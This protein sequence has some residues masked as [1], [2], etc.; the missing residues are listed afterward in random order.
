MISTSSCNLRLQTYFFIFYFFAH[1]DEPAPSHP[2]TP[3]K[4]ASGP[5]IKL[6]TARIHLKNPKNQF[7]TCQRLSSSSHS[8]SLAPPLGSLSVVKEPLSTQWAEWQNVRMALDSSLHRNLVLTIS[9][10]CHPSHSRTISYCVSF[11]S[12][13]SVPFVRLPQPTPAL[14][15]LRPCQAPPLPTFTP[16]TAFLL[17]SLGFWKAPLQIYSHNS[18][19]FFR[20]HSWVDFSLMVSLCRNHYGFYNEFK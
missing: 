5:R 12:V 2:P 10:L 9:S 8:V 4:W 3:L 17:V 14:V 19:E 16:A 11:P 1:F 15:R 20:K 18:G 7:S 6:T 13:A